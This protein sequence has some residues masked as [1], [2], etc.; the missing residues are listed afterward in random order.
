M[1]GIQYVCPNCETSARRLINLGWFNDSRA[2]CPQCN[3]EMIVIR[4]PLPK[5]NSPDWLNIKI[6]YGKKWRWLNKQ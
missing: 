6:K 3:E 5:K 4:E 1:K 2:V